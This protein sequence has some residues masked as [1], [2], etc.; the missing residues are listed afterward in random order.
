MGNSH[1]ERQ[2]GLL[3]LVLVVAVGV[4]I[5]GAFWNTAF[6]QS[7]ELGKNL[8]INPSFEEAPTSSPV[9]AGSKE[10]RV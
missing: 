9:P 3:L 6:A 2:G 4:G 7:S 10:V 1:V 8:V 5:R